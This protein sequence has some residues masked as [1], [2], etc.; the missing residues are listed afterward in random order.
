MT[1]EFWEGFVWKLCFV[2]VFFVWKLCFEFFCFVEVQ[3]ALCS[4]PWVFLISE[5]K[6]MYPLTSI[7]IFFLPPPQPLT[8]TILLF[9]HIYSLIQLLYDFFFLETCTCLVLKLHINWNSI[10]CWFQSLVA[11]EA[12]YAMENIHRNIRYTHG[13]GSE[14]L[15]KYFFFRSW[16]TVRY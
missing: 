12:V 15:C 2:F 1:T 13:S 9:L 8:T 10:F 3:K 7:S 5:S 6:V 14:S 16:G 4:C 11:R